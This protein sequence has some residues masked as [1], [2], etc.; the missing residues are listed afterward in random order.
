LFSGPAPTYPSAMADLKHVL[1]TGGNTGIGFALCKQLLVEHGCYVFLGSRNAEKGAAAV[2]EILAN[3]PDAAGRLEPVQIDATDG[4]SITA[5]A[6]AVRAKL[7]DAPL[8][9]IV[10]NAGTGLSH[11]VTGAMVIDTNFHGPKRVCDAFIPLLS[12]TEGRIVNVGSGAGPMY[13]A[14]AS[15]ED[16][17]FLKNPDI[18]WPELEGYV[19]QTCTPEFLEKAAIAGPYGL[20]KASLHAY[21]MILAKDFPNLLSSSMSPGFIDTAITK[22]FGASKS[23]EE[24][25]V[26]L[27]HCLFAP[28]EG[29]GWHYGSDGLR[30]PLDVL[31]N[32]GEPAYKVD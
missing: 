5:A 31:R 28:L 17:A 20:S 15:A 1:V 16:K 32:P 13:M 18:T 10:N 9:A 6:A 19:K 3:C 27:R 14:Q 24:G 26:S 23:P 7:G 8:Y 12:T 25:T 30:S 4:A 11:G 21:T 29:N 2:K 22:G